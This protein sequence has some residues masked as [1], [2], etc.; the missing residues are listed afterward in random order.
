MTGLKGLLIFLFIRKP[1][2]EPVVTLMQQLWHVPLA[3]WCCWKRCWRNYKKKDTGFLSFLRWEKEMVVCDNFSN[4]E[5]CWIKT[6]ILLIV[7]STPLIL[8]LRN[9]NCLMQNVFYCQCR[10]SWES[11]YK[12]VS[13]VIWPGLHWFCISSLWIRF[14]RLTCLTEN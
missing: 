1:L 13:K 10:F 6:E 2:V 4:V 12:L 14:S 11:D 8:Q 9:T 5:N 3:N 7:C